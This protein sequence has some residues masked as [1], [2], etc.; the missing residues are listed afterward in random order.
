MTSLLTS[1]EGDRTIELDKN[2]ADHNRAPNQEETRAQSF[3]TGRK[4]ELM[5]AI[6]NNIIFV[7]CKPINVTNSAMLFSADQKGDSR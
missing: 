2:M 6:E 4:R 5:Y 1:R 7:G 3:I